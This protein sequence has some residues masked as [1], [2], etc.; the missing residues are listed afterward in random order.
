MEPL[1]EITYAAA[2]HFVNSDFPWIGIMS[3][4]CRN[5]T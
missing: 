4:A 3:R 2:A 1:Q 5:Y